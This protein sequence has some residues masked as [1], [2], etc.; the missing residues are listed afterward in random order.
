MS[1]H[2]D[3]DE[4]AR[5]AAFEPIGGETDDLPVEGLTVLSDLSAEDDE[6]WPVRVGGEHEGLVEV[7]EPLGTV[8]ATR[9][10]REGRQG[11]A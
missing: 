11:Q 7:V 10:R 2:A 8:L 3:A 6:E 9:S 1:D 4:L 5:R